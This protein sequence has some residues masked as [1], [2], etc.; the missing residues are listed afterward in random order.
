MKDVI[1]IEEK[2]EVGADEIAEVDPMIIASMKERLNPK[3]AF[4]YA[5]GDHEKTSIINEKTMREKF[6]RKTSEV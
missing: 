3:P 2:I 5:N 1:I 6:A 4:S